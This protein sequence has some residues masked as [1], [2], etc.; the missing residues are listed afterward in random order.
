MKGDYPCFKA[1]YSHEE[2]VEHFLLSPAEHALVE[3]CHGE[4]NRHSVAVLLK[5]VQYLGYFPA[6]LQQV[7]P[8]IRTFIAHQ[9]HLL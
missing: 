7:P 2:L 3:T 9:L 1:A 5:T 8:A 4:T 6:D